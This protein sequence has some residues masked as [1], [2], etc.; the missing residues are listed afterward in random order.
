MTSKLQIPDPL[1]IELIEGKGNKSGHNFYWHIYANTV[2]A[3][4]VYIDFIEDEILNRHASIH[5]FLNKKSQ[6]KGIGRVAYAQACLKSGLNE[7]YAHMRKSNMASKKAAQ[8]AGFVE[9][10]DPRLSQLL[11]VWKKPAV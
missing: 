7:I 5:I 9:V 3:G 1:S 11:L 6:G 10:K 8:A 2:V 4:K